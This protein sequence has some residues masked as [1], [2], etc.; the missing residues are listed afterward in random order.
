[1]V[2]EGSWLIVS[3]SLLDG[4]LPNKKKSRHFDDKPSEVGFGRAW[5]LSVCCYLL[6]QMI[7]W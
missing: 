5:A 6:V 2:T 1:M 3:P 4:M 7:I